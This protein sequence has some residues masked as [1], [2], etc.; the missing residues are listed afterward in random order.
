MWEDRGGRP[1]RLFLA[2]AIVLVASA[3]AL[4]GAITFERG[5][6]FAL[7]V[8]GIAAG[9]LVGYWASAGWMDRHDRD[10]PDH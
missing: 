10:D 8:A 4:Y 2:L 3:A 5:F 6:G 9:S 1:P 7:L